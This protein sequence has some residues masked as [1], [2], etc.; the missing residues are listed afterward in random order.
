MSFRQDLST[1]ADL[2]RENKPSSKYLQASRWA[3]GGLE[4][5]LESNDG[6]D[7]PGKALAKFRPATE[8]TECREIGKKDK[9]NFSCGGS[10]AMLYQPP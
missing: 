1:F 10:S 7:F 8:P 6:S 9:I 5:K 2:S 4:D 3:P